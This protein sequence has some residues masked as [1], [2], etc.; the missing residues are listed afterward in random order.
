[1]KF[2]S[3]YNILLKSTCFLWGLLLLIGCS[4]DEEPQPARLIEARGYDKDTPLDSFPLPGI[5]G[6]STTIELV[7]D[8]PVLEV[9]INYSA[10]AQADEIPTTFWKLEGD[11]LEEVWNLQI[12]FNPERDVT[13]TIIYEDETGIHK[14]TLDVTL[15]AYSIDVFPPLITF[16]DPWNNEVN[17]DADRLNHEGI[18]IGFD[19]EMDNRPS[20][21]KIEVYSGQEM[22]NWSINCW[23]LPDDDRYGVHMVTLL[24]KSEDD[25]LLPKHEYEVHL[26][27]FY[28]AV[29]AR[30]DGPL[31]IRFQTAS[32]EPDDNTNPIVDNGHHE[33]FKIKPA[34]QNTRSTSH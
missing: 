10:K 4:A 22:L 16:L 33:P 3:F 11:Q 2:A 21:T 1:M 6:T 7:F 28:D 13:L 19:K 25:W 8:K 23:T 32:V 14:D 17:A 5:I 15:G 29:G 27:E 18:K 30:G 24:P 26:I 12:G 20:R 9:S 31:V 34:K